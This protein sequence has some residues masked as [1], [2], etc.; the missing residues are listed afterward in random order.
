MKNSQNR[1]IKIAKAVS[2]ACKNAMIPAFSCRKSRHTYMQYQ[3]ASIICMMKCLRLHY[4]SV[5]DLLRLTPVLRK[6]MKLKLLPH[7]TTIQKFFMRLEREEMDALLLETAKLSGFSGTIAIDS[8][9][10]TA[11]NASRH[12]QMFKYKKEKSP[13]K[14]AYMKGSA[15]IDIESQSIIVLK[16]RTDHAHDSRDFIPILREIHK[17][18]PV[19][20]IIADRGYDFEKLHRYA[21]N[22]IKA[23]TLI[24]VRQVKSGRVSG[25][26]RKMLNEDFDWGLYAKR[27][28][29]ESVFSGVKR[30]FGDM[31]FSRSIPLRMKEMKLICAVYNLYRYE[32]SCFVWYGFYKAV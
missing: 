15:A 28:R 7:Y 29:I 26:Y 17:N 24:P 18:V 19:N 30:K 22:R 6:V 3:H 8:T 11:S 5:M 14:K 23:K 31:L 13:W 16:C 27:S 2:V 1:L 25:K 32:R 4:R 10:F 12:Y 20:T 21:R 9:S